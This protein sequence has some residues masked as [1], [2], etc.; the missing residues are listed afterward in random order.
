MQGGHHAVAGQRRKSAGF[1]GFAPM[2]RLQ[3]QEQTKCIEL[4]GLLILCKCTIVPP[5]AEGLA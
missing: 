3:S 2:F 4:A 1:F 5:P